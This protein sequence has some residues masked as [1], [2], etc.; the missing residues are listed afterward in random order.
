MHLK[1][2]ISNHK[3]GI[4]STSF[5]ILQYIAVQGNPAFLH[6]HFGEQR[7]FVLQPYLRSSLNALAASGKSVHKGVQ[8]SSTLV[9]AHVAGEGTN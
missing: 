4:Y 9:H 5:H 6:Q 1:Q 2:I 3:K 8:E 7:G